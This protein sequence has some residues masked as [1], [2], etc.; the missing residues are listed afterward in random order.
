MYTLYIRSTG[1][2]GLV[3]KM[4][5]LFASC[6]SWF[7]YGLKVGAGLSFVTKL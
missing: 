4:V 6:V 7:L 5:N 1:R 3:T 2:L